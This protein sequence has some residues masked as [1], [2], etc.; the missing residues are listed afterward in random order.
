VVA[1]EPSEYLAI[2]NRLEDIYKQTAPREIELQSRT[3]HRDTQAQ[4]AFLTLQ[5]RVRE[6]NELGCRLDLESEDLEH[7]D[8]IVPLDEVGREQLADEDWLF[9]QLN[10]GKLTSYSGQYIGVAGKQIL[11]HNRSLKQLRDAV[12]RERGI[13]PQRLLTFLVDS[14]TR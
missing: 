4:R 1:T 7:P 13:P 9:E 6:L 8:E 11:G 3:K 12:E 5:Q 10:A 2:R 14:H